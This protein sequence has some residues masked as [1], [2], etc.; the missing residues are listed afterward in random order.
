MTVLEN[1]WAG[2]GMGARTQAP[3]AEDQCCD[4]K[5]V[6]SLLGSGWDGYAGHGQSAPVLARA[7]G[8]GMGV[9]MLGNNWR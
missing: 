8:A 5:M 4:G 6:N 9:E 3:V 1:S 7:A 2:I